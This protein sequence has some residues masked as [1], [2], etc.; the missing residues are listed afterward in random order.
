MPS[1]K[2]AKKRD[3]HKGKEAEMEEPNGDNAEPETEAEYFYGQLAQIVLGPHVP[4][5]PGTWFQPTA[6]PNWLGVKLLKPVVF[7]Y[8]KAAKLG[9]HLISIFSPSA[10][11]MIQW[12][13]ASDDFGNSSSPKR[14]MSKW[15]CRASRPFRIMSVS[16]WT[17]SLGY[18]TVT[19]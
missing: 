16:F 14:R 8:P 13:N 7:F 6:A 12:F 19:S 2:L 17:S 4:L 9:E 18:A 15:T 10:N 11:S 5:R 3:L 1:E